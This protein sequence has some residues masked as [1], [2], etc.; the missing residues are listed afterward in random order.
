MPGVKRQSGVAVESWNAETASSD[1]AMKRQYGERQASL[2]PAY[3]TIIDCIKSTDLVLTTIKA[4]NSAVVRGHVQNTNPN[5]TEMFAAIFLINL[6][7]ASERQS[8]GFTQSN[9]QR[10]YFY[11]V[12]F[13][14]HDLTYTQR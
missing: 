2:K 9:R 5:K 11:S 3:D 12:T 6:L 14:L 8:F 1:Q 13:I 4:W 7:D 10:Y